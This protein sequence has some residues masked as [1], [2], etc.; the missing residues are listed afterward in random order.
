MAKLYWEDVKEGQELPDVARDVNATLIAGGAIWAT[1]DFMPVHH[2][3]KFAQEKGAPDIFMNI[4]T[5]NGLVGAYVGN[6][7]GPDAELKKLTISLAVP[8][9][10]G[11]R[12]TLMGRVVKKYKDGGQHLVDVSI[13]G[14][15][16]MGPHVSGTATLALPSHA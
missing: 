1:H 4:L 3:P 11:A 9:F 5:D 7:A 6:W 2:D 10:P 15:N 8:N 14:E 12:L 13:T 16:S